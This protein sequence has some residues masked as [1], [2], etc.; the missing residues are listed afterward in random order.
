MR[1][2]DACVRS[3]ASLRHAL[4]CISHA[5]RATM[6]GIESIVNDTNTAMRTQRSAQ[7]TRTQ[8]ERVRCCR[9]YQ[10]QVTP[11]Y[12]LSSL[13][14]CCIFFYTCLH[15]KCRSP[16]FEHLLHLSV[17]ISLPLSILSCLPSNIFHLSSLN[18]Q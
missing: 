5:I 18:I 7:E 9:Q 12:P 4:I 3:H 6:I 10:A 2:E 8:E 13:L 1:A 14:L 11:P 15:L 17:L 16:P